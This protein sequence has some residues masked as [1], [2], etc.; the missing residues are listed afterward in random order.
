MG[1]T[2]NKKKMSILVSSALMV[3]CVACFSGMGLASMLGI[4][5]AVAGKIITIIDT[6]S[7]ITMIISLISVI[8]GAGV[9]ST[10][11][12]ATAKKMIKRYGKKY[13][14]MW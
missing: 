6:V 8:V 1:M 11:L 9:V 7:T 2:L 10:V 14:K 5:T 4:S 13:A 12:V 3:L